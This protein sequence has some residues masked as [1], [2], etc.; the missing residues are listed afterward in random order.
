MSGNVQAA[1][2]AVTEQI[3]GFLP[4]SKQDIM[5]FFDGLP[6]FFREVSAA[7]SSAAENM[8]DVHIHP[9][10][11]ES[12]RELASVTG[13]VADHAEQVNETHLKEHDVWIDD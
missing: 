9:N 7:F 3:G 2:E 12:M 11:I 13:G 4:Q 1:T 6:E 10:V 5:Q 8:T